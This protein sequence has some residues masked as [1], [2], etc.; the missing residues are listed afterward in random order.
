MVFRPTIKVTGYRKKPRTYSS[1]GVIAVGTTSIEW[2]LNTLRLVVRTQKY[3][4]V[5]LNAS[6]VQD[7]SFGSGPGCIRHPS[8]GGVS[9]IRDS[10]LPENDSSKV[11]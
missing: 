8:T 3:S 4:G 6:L 10:R 5:V 1:E 11:D 9:V 2:V 7:M